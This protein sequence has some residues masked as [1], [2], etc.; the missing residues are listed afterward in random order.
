MVLLILPH[1]LHMISTLDSEVTQLKKPEGRD[2]DY[3]D[4]GKTKDNE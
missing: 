4:R 3:C 2:K 1:T